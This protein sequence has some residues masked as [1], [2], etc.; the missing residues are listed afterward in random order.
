MLCLETPKIQIARLFYGSLVRILSCTGNR[1]VATI[2][3]AV[4][5]IVAL[6]VGIQGARAGDDN[7]Y[8]IGD[9]VVPPK[10]LS[11]V[12]PTYT[13]EART[14]GIE[15]TVQLRVVIGTDGVAHD[16][17]VV[18]RLDP[19]L[20]K[21]ALEAVQQWHFQPGTKGG[22]PVKVMVTIELNFRL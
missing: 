4:I 3:A 18:Q 12:E 20:D 6:L 22:A 16:L 11:K 15:G 17:K 9:G 14:A 5:A 19:G 2:P 21:K 7:V 13:P 10:V 1:R 8:Q